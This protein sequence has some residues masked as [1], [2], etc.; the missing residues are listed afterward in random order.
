MQERQDFYCDC[1]LK[2]L[3]R[4]KGETADLLR[5]WV[6]AWLASGRDGLIDRPMRRKMPP[7]VDAAI[8]RC[9]AAGDTVLVGLRD[10]RLTLAIRDA[11]G[12]IYGDAPQ[13]PY[14]VGLV[15]FHSLLGPQT[16]H[17]HAP[18]EAEREAAASMVKLGQSNA[19]WHIALCDLCKDTP[20][21]LRSR[22]MQIP[23]KNGSLCKKHLPQGATRAQRAS[24]H[25][26]LVK[27]A[28]KHWPQWTPRKHANRSAWI[29]LQVNAE[30]RHDERRITGSWITRYE[31]EIQE[32][33]V[34]G[35]S[36]GTRKN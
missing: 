6:G 27:L 3:N 5:G 9:V 22:I 20:F 4:E 24:D 33:I 21:F 17:P 29:A 15:G 10:L 36:D 12:R 34:K 23:Y 14:W 16:G 18:S 11:S 2:T 26:H 31:E 1:L 28:A 32:L 13:K 19:R 30:R 35:V 25:P 8:L 7:K